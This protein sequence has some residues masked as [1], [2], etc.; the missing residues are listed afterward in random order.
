MAKLSLKRLFSLGFISGCF[1]LGI[2][3]G[4]IIRFGQVQRSNASTTTTEPQL[5]FAIPHDEEIPAD[6]ITVEAGKRLPHLSC[7][8]HL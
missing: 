3:T 1:C 2:G 5:P 4:V 7:I 8:F 6:T